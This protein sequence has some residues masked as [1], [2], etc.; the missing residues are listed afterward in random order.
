MYEYITEKM[1]IEIE[2]IT[3]NKL[4]RDE[5]LDKRHICIACGA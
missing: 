2:K 3:Y 4:D 1:V 5:S